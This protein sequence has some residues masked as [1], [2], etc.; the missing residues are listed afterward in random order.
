MYPSQLNPRDHYYSHHHH[1]APPPVQ[2]MRGQNATLYPH[3]ASS[4]SYRVPPGSFTPQNTMNSGP[5]G[6]E[7]GSSHMGPVQPTGFRIYQHHQRDD[8]VPVATLRQHRGGVPRLRVMP[9]DVTFFPQI[10]CSIFF[11]FCRC[12]RFCF[13]WFSF[14]V[15]RKL[16]FWSLETSLVVLEIITLII[17]EI[18]DWTSRKCLTR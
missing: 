14:N 1:P 9:D 2:G 6:S 7:M 4:A 17:I 10:F 15:C 18:C 5:L 3:T 11:H 16:R 12:S 8:S 13:F